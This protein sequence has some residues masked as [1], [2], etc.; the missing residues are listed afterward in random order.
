MQDSLLLLS[1]TQNGHLVI[2]S[3]QFAAESDGKESK[4]LLQRRW[5]GK[6]HLGSVEG[7]AWQD[8][9][10][11]GSIATVG[12]DCVVNLFKIVL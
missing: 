4:C 9:V 2:W 12:G 7:L 3:V 11:E 8:M 6:L 10:D 1:T 5:K